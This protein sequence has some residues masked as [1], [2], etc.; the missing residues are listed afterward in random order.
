MKLL[1]VTPYYAP[2]WAYGSVPG[3]V[4][5]LARAQASLGHHVTVLT[6]DALAPHERL[7]VGDSSD[8]GV[9]VMRVRNASSSARTWLHLSTPIGMRRQARA[10]LAEGPDLVH[11]HELRTI[12]GIVITAETPRDRPLVV[13]PHGTLRSDTARRRATRAW[14]AL[15]GDRLLARADLVV[16]TTDE[17]ADAAQALW[18]S[19]R[20]SLRN[21]QLTVVP[22]GLDLSA[23]TRLP[24]RSAARRRFGLQDGPV[25]LASAPSSDT[26]WLQAVVGAFAGVAGRRPDARL[27]IVGARAHAGEA[28]RLLA[29]SLRLGDRVRV[30]GYLTEE[31]RHTALA[32]GDLYVVPPGSSATSRGLLE[33]M[34]SGL[35][36]VVDPRAGIGESWLRGAG[37][38]ASPTMQEWSDA[39]V[40]LLVSEETRTTLGARART[41]AAECTWPAVARRYETLYREV[42]ARKRA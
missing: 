26:D 15:V 30:E 21:N 1:H 11:L 12:E 28:V 24:D 3:T 31:A 22:D 38:I 7:P 42:M 41:V 8:E 34:A 2:A 37:Y 35:P 18:A 9:R 32:A 23:V 29:D 36:L 5:A 25:V 6:T 4:A 17:E 19:R 16:A 10:L 14:D 13:S 27:L 33:A 39:V 40:R 20:R